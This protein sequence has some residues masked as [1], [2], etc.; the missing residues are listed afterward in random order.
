MKTKLTLRYVVL[1]VIAIAVMTTLTPFSSACSK[2]DDQIEY[3][4]AD[5]FYMRGYDVVSKWD[6]HLN[7]Y[8]DFAP[9][10]SDGTIN[11]VIEIPA[12]TNAKFEVVEE[13]GVLSWEIKN[14]KP[15]II[16]YITYPGNYGMIPR[17]MGGDGD[18]LDCMTLG[19]FVLRATVQPAKLIGVMRCLDSGEVDDKLIAVLPGT[20]LYD[21]NSLAELQA[22]YPGVLDI[23]QTYYDNY[24]GPG[25]MVVLGFD[26]VDVAWQILSDA[27]AAYQP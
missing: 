11:V 13:T 23:L 15:R 3:L 24:K 25:K 14:G 19:K 18:S 7:F 17:T 2:K 6:R 16:D 20:G 9:L 26:D 10:N 27:M 12:G 8:R 22:K 5:G 1:V 4:L 21:C